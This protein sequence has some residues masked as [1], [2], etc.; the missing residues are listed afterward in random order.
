M[1]FLFEAVNTRA[2]DKT[3]AERRREH[4]RGGHMDHA[5]NGEGDA[6]SS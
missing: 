6:V 2:R 1:I 3:K 5:E 4:Q